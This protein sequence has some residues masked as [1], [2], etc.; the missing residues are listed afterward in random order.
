MSC[1]PFFPARRIPCLP[2]CILVLLATGL[3]AAD[4]TV[5]FPNG[6]ENQVYGVV[7]T[8]WT[9][10]VAGTVD[11][12]LLKGGALYQTMATGQSASGTFVYTLPGDTQMGEDFT[13][14][15]VLST[16]A[17]DTSDRVFRISGNAYEK[18]V[19]LSASVQAAPAQIT[20]AWGATGSDSG[21]N[22]F[23]GYSVYRRIP[24]TVSWGTALVTLANTATGW[25]DTA[26]A[27]GVPYEYRVL[28]F[29]GL[30]GS[31]DGFIQA[32]LDLPLTESRG[33]VVLA[34][35]SGLATA[36]AP[37]VEALRN[38]MRADGWTV[39]DIQAAAVQ[40][41]ATGYAAAV[42]GVKAQIRAAYDADPSRVKL[43]YVLGN[44]PVPYSGRIVPDGHSGDHLGAWPADVY[45]G[46][47]SEPW[48]DTTVNYTS[49][50]TRNVNVPGDGK[51]DTSTLTTQIELGVG[52]VDL[53]RL[54]VFSS[55]GDELALIRAYLT[56]A[57]AFRCRQRIFPSTAMIDDEFKT[58]AEGFAGSAWRGYSTLVGRANVRAAQWNPTL[59]A[60]PHLLAYGTGAGANGV[61][62]NVTTIEEIQQYRPQAVFT[63]L[64]GSY[65][66]DWDGVDNVLRG[67]LGPGAGLTC[68]WSGR[69]YWQMHQLATGATFGDL[70]RINFNAD[71]TSYPNSGDSQRKVHIALMGD[72]TLRL[73]PVAMPGAVV[74]R[75]MA[76]G[77]ELRW[78]A[79]ADGAAAGYHVYRAATAAG[80]F[81]RLSGSS[82]TAGNPSGSPLTA[83]SYA[84]GMAGNGTTWTYLVRTVK[85]EVTPSGTYWNQS[86]GVMATA[87]AGMATPFAPTGLTV[88][89]A[90]RSAFQLAWQDRSSDETSFV[91]E[92]SAGSTGTWA[93]VATLAANTT[94]WNDSGLAAGTIYWYRVR[95]ANAA[96]SSA[97]SASAADT[98]TP[99][100]LSMVATYVSTDRNGSAVTVSVQRTG[101]D[102]DTVQCSFTDAQMTALAGTDYVA[103]SGV[104]T[105]G[106]RDSSLR[107]ITFSL[108]PRPL[109]RLDAAFRVTISAPTNGAVLGTQ[110]W[111]QILLVNSDANVLPAGWSSEMLSG[112]AAS[113][114]ARWD[115]SAFSVSSD[116]RKN[117]DMSRFAYRTISGDFD[118]RMR[119]LRLDGTMYGGNCMAMVRADLTAS[120]IA[121]EVLLTGPSGG[122]VDNRRSATSGA[123]TS[124]GLAWGHSVPVWLRI[125][126]SA[127]TL[128]TFK[129]TDGT[130]WNQVSTG[131]DTLPVTTLVGFGACSND[132]PAMLGIAVVDQV[133]L[134]S[135]GTSPPTATLTAGN[136]SGAGAAT[137]AIQV[138]YADPDGVNVSSIGGGDLRVT[139]AAG[140]Q[141][142][143]TLAGID[144]AGNGTPRT[145]TYLVPAPG[146][147]WDATD[148]GTYTVALLEAAVQDIGGTAT[149]G[150]ILGTFQVSIATSAVAPVITEGAT[151]TA[152][153]SED[154]S[155]NAFVLV[156]HATDADSATLAW[157][158]ATQAGHGTAAVS[159]GGL[160]TAVTYVPA[161]NWN[162]SDTFVVQVSDGVLS[163]SIAVTVT[164]QAVNDA[165]VY[166][167][168]PLVSGSAVA[169]QNLMCSSGSWNDNRDTAVGGTSTCS[170]A[171]QWWLA[172]DALGA[173][174]MAI[175]GAT[176]SAYVLLTTDA[177]RWVRCQV[178]CSDDGVG[179][180][181]VRSATAESAWMQVTTPTGSGSAAGTQGNGG[182]GGCGAGVLSL[183]IGVFL[184]SLRQRR[185]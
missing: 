155:P 126:R 48:T 7:Y 18:I 47:M 21:T 53:A 150:Q 8:G 69:P 3:A 20:L 184:V 92:R 144:T 174:P 35:E 182:G 6:D 156:L 115:G 43:V 57:H 44:V 56:K 40:V 132:S 22:S 146:G 179:S 74:A 16:G 128:A 178:T 158:V 107:T 139:N 167:A 117:L 159:A 106:H 111:T 116:S 129:S 49:T 176:S 12:Q 185:R 149:P 38:D 142:P 134:L 17:S 153:M 94:A 113:G 13:V 82:A 37:E 162:G 100:V 122:I 60:T 9:S 154:G 34:V 33:T 50:G 4:I 97:A 133:Q 29:G 80:P 1:R 141:L 112:L 59:T 119:V 148:N 2:G 81:T 96:G 95:A 75:G 105:W 55:S 78:N 25:S 71:G 52:R 140:T 101:G 45:Y 145:A 24:G 157:S 131:A 15:A 183:L 65:F 41:G 125:Q 58:Y 180:P 108:P 172:D 84:D 177:G 62:S 87:T 102:I 36:L 88:R 137:H 66:G 170:Y 152:T 83:L 166:T 99:G 14:R 91:V 89:A 73:H 76:G 90:S 164:V 54:P 63:S 123:V 147:S 30:R 114:A 151:A 127:G 121:T 31:A 27:T 103:S 61:V 120:S 118:F 165:P 86:V 135:L 110:K 67:I 136:V 98:G 72:P 64:F 68:F 138:R 26:V 124:G 130:T 42:A 79:S 104:L 39:A 28:R 161:S 85:R 46:A 175:A 173:N 11:L 70:A 181:A 10:T 109:P 77:I 160:S 23:T 19:P 163:D 93:T 32:G 168:G 143:P 51:F 169:G 5:N 171:Y